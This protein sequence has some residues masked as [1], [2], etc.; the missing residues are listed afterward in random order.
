MFRSR[1]GSYAAGMERNAS[2]TNYLTLAQSLAA[3][4]PVATICGTFALRWLKA[5]A[6]GYVESAVYNPYWIGAG[7]VPRSG[8]GESTRR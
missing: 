2:A 7:P 5:I 8:I 1:R 4:P 3:R 6:R